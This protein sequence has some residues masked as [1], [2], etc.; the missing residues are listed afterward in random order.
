M[1]NTD[2][3]DG[4]RSIALVAAQRIEAM[5]SLTTHDPFLQQAMRTANLVVAQ[6]GLLQDDL[7]DHDLI[8]HHFPQVGTP[9]ILH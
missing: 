8:S 4:P 7:S 1:T 2:L 9:V 6:S 3:N 5:I